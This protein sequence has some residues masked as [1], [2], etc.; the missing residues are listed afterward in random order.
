MLTD[1]HVRYTE[2]SVGNVVRGSVD[3][4]GIGTARGKIWTARGKIY[5]VD[6]M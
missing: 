3:W 4:L 1:F 6:S 2:R 5:G